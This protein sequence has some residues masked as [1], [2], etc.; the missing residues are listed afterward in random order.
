MK[1]Q[2]KRY[3]WSLLFAAV[4]GGLLITSCSDDND[5]STD[6]S[7]EEAERNEY[8]KYDASDVEVVEK[9]TFNVLDELEKRIAS[10]SDA[11]SDEDK[12][13]LAY[14][15]KKYDDLQAFAE[16]TADSIAAVNPGNS[17]VA[18]LGQILEMGRATLSYT[19][20]G[21]DGK[22]KR[23][24]LLVVY[25]IRFFT[26]IDAQNIILGCHY[27]IT[28][29]HERP[30][31]T[32]FQGMSDACLLGAEWATTSNYLVVMPDYEGYGDSKDSTHPYLNR[33]VQARQTLKALIVG[34]NWF[35]ESHGEEFASRN[36]V[37]E[38]YSQGGAVAAATY[39]YWLE[40]SKEK[41]I[42]TTSFHMVGAVCGDGPY[43]PL[44][45]AL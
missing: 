14:Y 23:M 43:D 1:Q 26:N 22:N 5:N 44:K 4:F 45:S 17:K 11:N 8:F 39:R 41:W 29:D 7:S 36:V 20:K 31:N 19:D 15:K 40:H 24:T 2:T 9:T 12:A 32:D 28:S 33:E 18:I 25:P 16:R 3:A 34:M 42:E 30:T 13:M 37:V 27:T 38:G 6:I 10:S 35:T 21:A